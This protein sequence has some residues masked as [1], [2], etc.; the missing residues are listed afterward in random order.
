LRGRFL[1]SLAR[2]VEVSLFENAGIGRST[3]KVLEH[4]E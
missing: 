1:G 4:A 2:L 3:G